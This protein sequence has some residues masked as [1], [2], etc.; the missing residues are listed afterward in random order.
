MYNNLLTNFKSAENG[1]GTNVVE[2]EFELRH[3][4]KS[5]AYLLFVGFSFNKYSRCCIPILYWH[6]E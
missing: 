2:L 6:K 3:S 5:I 4:T 1:P